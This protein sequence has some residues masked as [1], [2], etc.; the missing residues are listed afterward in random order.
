MCIVGVCVCVCWKGNVCSCSQ[1]SQLQ[2]QGPDVLPSSH[3]CMTLRQG[4]SLRCPCTCL[5]LLPLL[6]LPLLL[7][8]LLQEMDARM[9]EVLVFVDGVDAMTSKVMQARRSYEPSEMMLNEQVC[10]P[11]NTLIVWLAGSVCICCTAVE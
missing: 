6:L 1:K 4:D 9:M 8:P 10:V 2:L 5:T 11:N 7:L 3:A